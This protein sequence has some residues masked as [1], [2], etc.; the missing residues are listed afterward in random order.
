MKI[1]YDVGD[2]VE[3]GFRINSIENDRERVL[4]ERRKARFPLFDSI[5]IIGGWEPRIMVVNAGLLVCSIALYQYFALWANLWY[6]DLYGIYGTET[7]RK[8][9][10]MR[11]DVARVFR[12]E[13]E[14][15]T[16]E[17]AK[18]VQSHEEYF[19]E[20]ISSSAKV[21]SHFKSVRL[22]N[23]IERILTNLPLVLYSSALGAFV[24]GLVGR[25]ISPFLLGTYLVFGALLTLPFSAWATARADSVRREIPPVVRQEDVDVA[26]RDKEVGP[27]EEATQIYPKRQ[28]DEV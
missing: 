5:G 11:R 27:P 13:P 23:L 17:I 19:H 4:R 9:A 14:E 1:P 26:L 2:F 21:G 24:V 22:T 15:R 16:T 28:E 6:I 18:I 7:R 3:F 25:I 12:V 8:A 20:A 10:I